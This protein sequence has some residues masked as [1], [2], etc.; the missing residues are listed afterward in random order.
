MVNNLPANAGDARDE[1]LIPG[2]E[3]FHGGRQDPV[4][5]PGESH[6]QRSL[7]GATVHGITESNT[8]EAT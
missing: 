7:V 2:S 5:L 3:R 1:D 8:T 4:F 6:E